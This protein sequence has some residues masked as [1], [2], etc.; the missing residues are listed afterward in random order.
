M[1][2]DEIR[3]MWLRAVTL[4]A[5]LGAMVLSGCGGAAGLVVPEPQSYGPLDCRGTHGVRACAR[6]DYREAI[7]RDGGKLYGWGMSGTPIVL[8]APSGEI[9]EREEA[10][11]WRAVGI[12]NRSLPPDQKLVKWYS[13]GHITGEELG[14]A[15][16]RGRLDN[17]RIWAGFA[18]KPETGDC[19]HVKAAGCGLVHAPGTRFARTVTKGVAHVYPT[20]AEDAE[21]QVH[22]MVHEL[23]HALGISGHPQ[24]VHTSL[25]SYEHNDDSGILDNLPP[26]DAA[27]L[28]EL[29]GWG[30]WNRRTTWTR[31]TTLAGVEFGAKAY[32]DRHVIPYVDAGH[33]LPPEPRDLYGT[34]SYSGRFRGLR[35]AS[36]HVNADVDIDLDLRTHQGNIA[37]SGW[38]E[39][40]TAWRRTGALDIR[41]GLVLREHWFESVGPGGDFD[42]NGAPDVQG[43]LYS[44]WTYSEATQPDVAAGTLERGSLVGG[45]GSEKD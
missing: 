30:N 27:M 18:E 12:I 43:A 23:L 6:D 16:W 26:I 24:D 21:G 28:Y 8:T 25:M 29:N 10:V 44:H 36:T 41:Y 2:T 1:K 45:F 31:N 20:V 5:L 19:G 33:M 22:V 32:D 7:E 42:D 11:V 17:G 14:T 39:Y 15:E 38:E 40:R 3:G 4:G 35:G 37:F 34:A 9:S 13:T